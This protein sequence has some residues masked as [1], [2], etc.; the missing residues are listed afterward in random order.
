MLEKT[1][2]SLQNHLLNKS[3]FWAK[4]SIQVFKAKNLSIAFIEVSII[5]IIL[6]HNIMLYILIFQHLMLQRMLNKINEASE[7]SIKDVL[8]KLFAL[9]GLCSLEKHISTLYEGSFTT[10]PQLAMLREEA[11]LMLCSALKDDAIAL[12]DVIAPPD[13]IL[14]SVLGASDGEVHIHYLIYKLTKIYNLF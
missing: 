10:S 13:F 14:N 3:L 6:R 9:F 4:S 2:T 7:K 5:G 1:Y 8:H 11:I 12:I